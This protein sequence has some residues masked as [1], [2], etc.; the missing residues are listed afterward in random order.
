ML[1][2]RT[3]IC[4]HASCHSPATHTPKKLQLL[5]Q[6]LYLWKAS[7]ILEGQ[8][9]FFSSSSS[10]STLSMEASREDPSEADGSHFPFSPSS[11]RQEPPDL[12]PQPS[13]QLFLQ[14]LGIVA[15]GKRGTGEC[16]DYPIG[17]LR[18]ETGGEGIPHLA[19]P[20]RELRGAGNL[21]GGENRD[22]ELTVLGHLSSTV[23]RGF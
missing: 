17:I 19:T 9:D 14:D 20:P 16:G 5:Q 11:K 4:L 7:S 6:R 13:S 15:S 12:N 1:L 10:A 23:Q 2:S 21:C 8:E 18:W 22:T 3:E